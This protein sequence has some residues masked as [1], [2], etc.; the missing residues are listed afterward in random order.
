MIFLH[1]RPPTSVQTRPHARPQVR[2]ATSGYALR[3]HAPHISHKIQPAVFAHCYSRNPAWRRTSGGWVRNHA[4]STAAKEPA[5]CAVS[6]PRVEWLLKTGG[7]SISTL[8]IRSTSPWPVGVPST[9]PRAASSNQRS[10]CA[11][12]SAIHCLCATAATDVSPM[13]ASVQAPLLPRPVRVFASGRDARDPG[14][15]TR[16]ARGARRQAPGARHQAPGTRHQ[17]PGTRLEGHVGARLRG[18]A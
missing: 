16:E 7:S 6:E 12:T 8:A 13:A 11:L 18:R 2:P 9:S 10:Y 3:D 1:H 17:A 14:A 4:S 15:F 5:P